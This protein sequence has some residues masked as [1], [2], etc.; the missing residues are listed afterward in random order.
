MVSRV[1]ARERIP[2]ILQSRYR[3]DRLL[4]AGGES[5][6]YAAHDLVLHRDVVVKLRA[7]DPLSPDD[8]LTQQAEALRHAALSH[9]ALTTLFD[10]GVDST[11][12]EH[13][14]VYSVMEHVLGGDLR[15]WLRRGALSVHQVC[16]LGHDLA[17]AADYLHD[18]GLIHRDIKPANVLLAERAT[19]T[20]IRGKLTDFG[21]AKPI[22]DREP[23][24]YTVGTAAYLSPEQVEGY[25]ATP[26]SDTYALGLVLIESLTG[27]RTF[28]GGIEQS[29]FARLDRQPD[30]PS[31]IPGPL[32][33]VLEQM[34]AR[35]PADRP[36]LQDV[37]D[38]LQRIVVGGARRASRRVPLPRVLQRR[39]RHGAG[40]E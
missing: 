10:A 15:G 19:D 18:C 22:G 5:S 23:G 33:A 38:L 14:Q 35:R 31:D 27:R 40:P 36:E 29:A 4:G 7:A 28:P 3:L 8:L 37:A 12:P 26:R 9:H 24:E 20:R 21:I 34:T 13:P 25:D 17:E 2:E 16:W 39:P 11:D 6:V 30:V 1:V 32:R